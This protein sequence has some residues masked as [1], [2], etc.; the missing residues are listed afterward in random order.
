D[1]SDGSGIR[2]TV[3]RYYTPSGR[4]I[5]KPYGSKDYGYDIY[6]RYLGGEVFSADS[7]KLD[8]SDVHYTRSGRPVYGGGGIMPDVFVPLDTTRA[9]DFYIEC[10]RKAV[11]M[12]YASRVFDRYGA[13]LRSIDSYPRMD[14]FL[15]KLNVK[16]DFPAY[17]REVEGIR[18]TEAEWDVTAPYLVPQLYALVARYSKL[19]ENAFYKYYLPVDSTLQEALHRLND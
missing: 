2:L 8:R 1:M 7:I 12:R 15:K 13:T 6:K 19:G 14:A 3:A 16:V 4:C 10:N 5:Q 18:C 17:A 11:Q 9:S